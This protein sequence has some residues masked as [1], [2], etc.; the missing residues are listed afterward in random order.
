[1]KALIV[2]D[3]RLAADNL[4][5]ILNKAGNIEILAV[6]ESVYEVLEWFGQ[7]REPDILFLDI[8]L[9]DG[10]AF[11]FFEKREINCP[12]IFTTAYDEYALKAF[13]VNSIDYLLKPID[14]NAVLKSLEKHKKLTT[15]PTNLSDE[16]KNVVCYFRKQNVYKTSFLIPLKG[17]KLIPLKTDDILYFFIDR[18]VVKAV[19]IENKS[20][21]IDKTLDEVSEMVDPGLFFR[22][23][24]Q[25]IISRKAINDIDLW[26]NQRLSVNLN[27]P[28]KKKIIISKAKIQE[29]KQW[30]SE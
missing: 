13:K 24:R 8:H 1:M 4:S 10:S 16:I 12:V 17:D 9:A 21:I 2:E 7:N 27:I 23:N 20:F 25:F 18:G 29:F 6:L 30:F 26:F 15:Q 28:V 14:F 3:E 5:K 19:A 11:E 22:A